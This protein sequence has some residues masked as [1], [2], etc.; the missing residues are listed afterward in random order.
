MYGVMGFSRHFQSTDVKP[1]KW[2][3]TLPGF[4]KII[5]L[6]GSRAI[7][8]LSSSVSRLPTIWEVIGMWQGCNKL[9]AT[10]TQCGA[11]QT[12]FIR[13][14]RLPW[15]QSSLRDEQVCNLRIR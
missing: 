4:T 10:K 11:I 7:Q 9:W 1:P 13:S 6:V 15:D 12:C 3:H 5:I 8:K 14:A 2:S